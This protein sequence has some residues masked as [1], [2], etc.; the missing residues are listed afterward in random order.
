MTDSFDCRAVCTI[1]RALM[2]S[3]SMTTASPPASRATA[4]LRPS[5]TAATMWC[6]RPL[7]AGPLL[8][9]SSVLRTYA[10]ASSTVPPRGASTM[11]ERAALRLTISRSVR[12]SGLPVRQTTR[13]LPVRRAGAAAGPPSSTLS[14]SA[15]ID[16]GGPAAAA[17]GLD[18]FGDDR[19]DLVRP[20]EDHGVV[21]L[22][23]QRATLAQL[24][25]PL[26]AGRW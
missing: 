19:V 4:R 7:N 23:H 17:V 8:I 5:R 9:A 15:R 6:G 3:P 24:L 16:D 11:I 22:D 13:V 2:S 10:S 1:S 12:S 20:A 21:R 25:Q 26:V 18:Q 14:C